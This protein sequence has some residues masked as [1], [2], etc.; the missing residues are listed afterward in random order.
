[1]HGLPIF[2]ELAL[3]AA[4]A[5]V[6][7]MLLR[8]LRLP[9][10]VAFLVTGVLI[11]PGGLG[12]VG[13]PET[14]RSLA[15]IGIVMLL[16]AVGLEFSIGD[17]KRLGRSGAIAGLVQ[18]V[19]TAGLA[20]AVLMVVGIPPARAVFFGL[21]VTPSSTALV[22]RMITERGEF[23]SPHGKLLT[24]VLLLQDLALVPMVLLVPALAAWQAAMGD[25][26]GVA[27]TAGHAL[28]AG[29]AALMRAILVTIVVVLAFLAASRFVPWLLYR[30]SLSRSR[31]TFL[32]AVLLIV[33]GSAYLSQ[34]AGLSLALGAFLAGLAL[35]ESEL[36]SQVIADVLPFRDT[37]LSVFFVSIGMLLLPAEVVRFPGPVLMATIGMVAFKLACGAI[38]ARVAGLPWRVA[39]AGGIGLAQVGE[40]SFVLAQVGQPLGL[41]PPPWNQSFLAGAVFSMMLAPWLVAR[42][43]EWALRV[44]LLLRRVR[45][46]S[47][48]PIERTLSEAA[49]SDLLRDHVI[50]G[51]FGLNGQNLARVLRAVH[52]PHI[53]VDL[54]ADSIARCGH[55]GS[56]ALVGNVTQPENLKHAGITRARV[57]V[58]A[59]S[60]P[61]ASRH[62]VRL[63]R[64]LNSSVFILVRTHTIGEIDAIHE[65]G[66]NLVIP[67]EFETSIEIFS[68]VL[69]EYHVPMNVVD[70]QVTLLR[71]ER[72]SLLRGLKLPKTVIEQLDAILTQG[73]TEAV[74][75]LH[76]S[77]VV[78]M[79]LWETQ[80]LEAPGITLVAI[81]RGG[82]AMTEFDPQIELRVGDTLV[83]TGDHASIDKVVERLQP[84]SLPS[85]S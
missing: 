41:L 28:A 68:A 38:A 72:Y 43:P 80:L 17:L 47:I 29:P 44:E 57:I 73:T 27:A 62:A 70:A 19:L 63:A 84:T 9:S 64:Q 14:V 22:L 26:P 7:S 46:G 49:Q 33:L 1:M 78:G 74:V 3:L 16:F 23:Q 54:A 21:L 66:A 75:L 32:A 82:H 50:I 30:A 2:G 60:D 77:P 65:A 24:A 83:V 79:A 45:P 55:D 5:L 11:G 42:A 56:P 40:F 67:E 13:E 6:V 18:I 48:L 59:L 36:K 25:S 52:I 37:L 4:A 85:S 76:H 35:A 71:Q 69:R 31:E 81:V 39:L 58:F 53:V 8:Y 12:L 15:E 10:V 51:G 34:Q 61:F 20:T